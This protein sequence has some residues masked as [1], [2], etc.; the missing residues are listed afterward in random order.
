M[1]TEGPSLRTTLETARLLVRPPRSSD[2][3][4]LL[5]AQ[6]RNEAHLRPWS[7]LRAGGDHRPS[8][9]TVAK[10]VAMARRCWRCDEAY[11]FYLFD[12]EGAEFGAQPVVGRVTLGRVLRGPF[13]N[14]FLGYWL[15][16]SQQRR[17]LMTEAVGAVVD[18]AFGALA[19][20][21]VQASIM[22]R[23]LSSVRVVEKLGFRHEG[24]SRR[25]LHIAGNWEDHAIY[26]ITREEW[27]GGGS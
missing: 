2:V 13:Q 15:D 6:R 10:D 12:R 3:T 18:F 14:S 22:P 21:R 16:V 9:V 24:V 7:P 19:L 17:G 23:N 27:R 1:E 8:L 20:H 5:A 26:A 11:T 4:L 25:Y